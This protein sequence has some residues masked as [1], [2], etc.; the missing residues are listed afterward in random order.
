[1]SDLNARIAVVAAKNKQNEVAMKIWEARANLNPSNF[2]YMGELQRW[3]L[4]E[5][6]VAFYNKMQKKMPSSLVPEK[7]LK[8]LG[9]K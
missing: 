3:G 8:W 6:L 2:D 1:L 9:Q 7:A 5:D 4:T